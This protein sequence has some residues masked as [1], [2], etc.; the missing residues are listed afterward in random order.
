MNEFAEVIINSEAVEI[1]RPFTYKVKDDLRD[2]IKIGHR[3]LVP[4][5]NGNKKVEGF[6]INLCESVSKINIKYKSII[7]LCDEEPLL[8]NDSFEIIKFLKQKYLCKYIDAIRIMIPPK[9]MN[10]NK[11]KTKN[12]ICFS[13]Y[14]KCLNTNQLEALEKIKEVSGIF[15]K[16]ELTN[17]FGI[18]TYMIN[19]LLELNCIYSEKVKVDRSNK[20]EF[21]KYPPKVLN[22]E[23]VKAYDIILE[24]KKSIFLLKGV[25]GSGKTE[26]YM[27][28]VSYMLLLDKTS[29]ILVPE[30][31][32]TPQMIE[33]FKGR[34][35][36]EVA[37]FHSKLSDGE[38]YDEWYRVKN[39]EVKL[40]IGARS[41][42]FL[43]FENLGLIVVD[44]EH[45]SSY[46]SEMNPKYNTIEVCEF[47]SKLKKCKIVLGS[48]TPSMESYYKSL[49]GYYEL[50]ELKNRANKF[51]LPN[52]TIIDMRNELKNNN[53]SMFSKELFLKMKDRLNK[54]EQII[55]FLNRRGFS[56]FVSCRS[57]GYVF[58]CDHCDISMTYHNNGFL[59]CHYCGK[60]KR[61]ENVCPKCNSSYVKYFG[62]GTEKVE[63]AVKY[64][65][66]KAKVLRMDVDTTRKKDSH[67]KIYNEFKM[68]NADILIGTQM[69]AKGLDFENV[70]LV[71]V[72]AA[73][74]TLN[75]PDFKSSERTFQILTQV[76][77]RA[78]RGEKEGE[79]IIQTYSPEHYG[80]IY[81]KDNNY[82]GFF[83]KEISIRKIMDYPPFTKLFLVTLT[84]MNEYKLIN[85]SK[86]LK[87]YFDKNLNK[88]EDIQIYPACSCPIGK[89]KNTYRWQ[90]LIKGNLN[91]I[92]TND[93]KKMVYEYSK[94]VYNEIKVSL[95][96][97]PN[98]LI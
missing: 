27:N 78:G 97:N 52:I 94:D 13:K 31:A 33:R 38:R 83:Q 84:G 24:S 15:N 9:I 1:D 44:E 10:G 18:S 14:I 64:Y 49:K 80:I 21:E 43:P 79:V 4:F 61:V 60:T 69:I 55:L 56:T 68:G 57:C 98:S 92:I 20:K 46:K 36:K 19:K 51:N 23:Q 75:L 95:D 34:F 16:A 47:I 28:L 65:F 11:E 88:Y 77:G 89:I 5:G 96:I 45:E 22:E 50:I 85:F 2:I 62:L 6:V 58:K 3:V 93:I 71:G 73:D 72:L 76:S 12:I 35:G 39:G 53:K 17:N 41:A 26:V 87:L 40:V 81:A 29:L 82:E 32:L 70:T 42:I 59:V 54:K 86:K 74:T 63:E 7:K 25:T 67:A 30:I 66:P 90:I 91:D 37:V 48:A 8:T